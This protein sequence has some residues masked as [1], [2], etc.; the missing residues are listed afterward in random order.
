MGRRIVIDASL[1]LSRAFLNLTGAAPQ[2]YLL[3]L[4][5]RRLVKL[6]RAGKKMGNRE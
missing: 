1:V 6:V 5:K 4:R 3:F 2:V